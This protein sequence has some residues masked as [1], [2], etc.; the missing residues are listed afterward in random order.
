MEARKAL[1]NIQE[2]CQDWREKKLEEKAMAEIDMG[3]MEVCKAINAFARIHAARG[4]GRNSTL[5]RLII[6]GPTYLNSEGKEQKLPSI[7]HTKKEEIHNAIIEHNIQHFSKAEKTPQGIKTFLYQ[8]LGDH[9]TSE[10]SN[11]ILNG[12][13]T[14][15]DKE[16]FQLSETFELLQA[17]TRPTNTTP[18]TW[19]TESI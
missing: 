16:K 7:V 13:L 11:R 14:K 17:T 12:E 6:P 2:K 3:D 10:F 8:A 1:N 9:G 19:V 4:K 5:T 18:N 15:T